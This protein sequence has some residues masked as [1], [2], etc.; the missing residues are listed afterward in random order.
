MWK[1][2]LYQQIKL[3]NS[4]QY[5]EVLHYYGMVLEWKYKLVYH[6]YTQASSV[7]CI[8]FFTFHQQKYI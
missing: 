3:Q 7:M 6:R 5:E 2:S 1:Y 8:Y 4:I